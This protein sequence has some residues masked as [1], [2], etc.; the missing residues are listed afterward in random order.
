VP[1]RDPFALPTPSPRWVKR[2]RVPSPSAPQF[3]SH[4]AVF[5]YRVPPLVFED[6]GRIPHQ[7]ATGHPL[8]VRGQ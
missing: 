2:S 6:M 3:V 7:D 4:D 5:D 8:A 1:G